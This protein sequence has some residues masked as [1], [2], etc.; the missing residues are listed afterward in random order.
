MDMLLTE[1]GYKPTDDQRFKIFLTN[2]LKKPTPTLKPYLAAVDEADQ[3]AYK[4]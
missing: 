3:V 1:T 4:T 2:S